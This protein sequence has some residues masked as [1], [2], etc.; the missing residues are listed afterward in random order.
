M[1]ARAC[2]RIVFFGTDDVAVATLAALDALRPRL[3]RPA[4]L[5]VVAP[6]SAGPVSNLCRQL[7]IPVRSVPKG[8][9]FLLPPHLALDPQDA[10]DAGDDAAAASSPPPPPPPGDDLCVVVSFGHKLAPE[11][12]SRFRALRVNAHPSILPRHAGAAPLQATLRCGDPVAGVTLQDVD[13]RAIDAGAA[14][15]RSVALLAPETT[16]TALRRWAAREAAVLVCAAVERCVAEN[17]RDVCSPPPSFP[18]ALLRARFA[19]SRARKPPRAS[20][21]L[22]PGA[23]S[24]AECVGTFRSLDGTIGSWLELAQPAG[25]VIVSAASALHNSGAMDALFDT[26]WAPLFDSPHG[27]TEITS[28]DPDVLLSLHNDAWDMDLNSVT[29]GARDDAARSA[30]RA[31]LG[32][33]ASPGQ[34]VYD[35]RSQRLAARCTDGWMLIDAVR[36]PAKQHTW[37]AVEFANAAG[38][39]GKNRVPSIQILPINH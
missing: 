9:P 19:H 1:S 12:L 32:L 28:I 29:A 21:Q 3:G 35:R 17:A 4:S 14:L 26:H 15:A 27:A 25:R 30:L 2:A 33:Q 23:Q 31:R 22:D 24:V 6:E 37:T 13:P 20:S 34:L 36:V 7:K 18:P 5:R 11:T 39:V 8:T 10:V 38:L 16:G